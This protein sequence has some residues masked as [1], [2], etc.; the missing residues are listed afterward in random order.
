MK[1]EIYD[2]T[3][4]EGSQAAG[5]H[6]SIEDRVEL[7]KA[8]DS[9]GMD[10]IELGWPVSE[11]VLE[12]FEL[13]RKARKNA[14]IVA[15]GSTSIA[16]NPEE[17]FNLLGIIESKPDF[18]CIFGKTSKEHVEKQLKIT[19]EEN[20][21][22]IHDSI[23]FLKSRG[24]RVF[25]DAEHYF[26]SFK[27]DREYALDTLVSAAK[28]GAEKIILCDT[29]GGTLPN[30]V[31]YIVLTTREKLLEKDISIG[32]GVH[33]HDDSGLA[34]A[35]TLASLPY[36]AQVQ[37]TINGIG[38]RIGNLNFS[39]FLPIY[40]KKIPMPEIKLKLLKNVNEEAYRLAG[41][42]IPHSRAF[43]GDTAFAHKGGVHIDAESKGASYQHAN[44]EDYGNKSII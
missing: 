36:I 6:F 26:D 8:L 30:E 41:L 32:L 7:F 35:N 4:R 16:K 28:A 12:S 3:L 31:E 19:L 13:C 17:D 23:N 9:F 20:I 14:K 29:N 34:L 43:V 33:F 42:E 18:A 2:C 39:E 25:Y 1:I 27:E 21:K 11:E 38:E 10:Y 37:G 44:P 5:A 15:F 24:I 22:K 40:I